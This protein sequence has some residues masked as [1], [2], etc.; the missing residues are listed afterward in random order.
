MGLDELQELH[1]SPNL[2]Y[3]S[4]ELEHFDDILT[5]AVVEDGWLL[6][7]KEVERRKELL[8]LQRENPLLELTQ[9][10]DDRLVGRIMELNFW[11]ILDERGQLLRE[12][13]EKER[14]HGST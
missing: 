6:V 4:D 1:P 13:A 7:I 5:K 8:R 10:Q 11:L 12:S 9:R 3:T 14:R 2:V